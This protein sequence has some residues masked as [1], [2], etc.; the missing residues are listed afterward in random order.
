MT[1]ASILLVVLASA[2][3]V[4]QVVV[5][6]DR[7]QVTR[8]AEVKCG[9][10]TEL[11]FA[12]IPPAADFQSIRATARNATVEGL[13]TEEKTREEAFSK[14]LAKLDEELE[15]VQ[16]QLAAID[17]RLRRAQN[18]HQL[19]TQ[20]DNVAVALI[21]RDLAVSKPDPKTWS[22]A[23]DTALR[24]KLDSAAQVADIQAQRRELAYKASDLQLKRGRL[25]AASARK[26]Y[27]AE[28]LV[29]CTKG[30]GQV[31]LTYLVG[32]ASWQPAY[33]ARAEEPA[34]VEVQTFAT[35]TQATGEDWKSAKILLSTAVPS[36]DA[37]PPEIQPLWV[38]AQEKDEKKVLVRREEK[39]QHAKTGSA[40]GGEAAP[41]L[42]SRWQGLSV[43]L[44][45]QRP[46]DVPGDGSPVRLFVGKNKMPAKFA[47][48]TAPTL[49]PFVFRTAEVTNTAA[50]PLLAGNLDAFGRSG[51]VGRFALERTAT[52]APFEVTLGIED[53][54]KV[55][56]H[57]LEEVKKDAGLFNQKKR[58][59][60]AYRFEVENHSN[61]QAEIELSDRIPVSELDD[62]VVTVGE[63]TTAG[64][65]RHPQDGV[66]TWKVRLGPG[67]TTTVD[68]A[69]YVDVPDSYDL[70]GL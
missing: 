34:H 15:G 5:Y 23:F 33:E 55:K 62:V 39:I 47:Y 70:A 24:A 41:N 10:R 25:A 1:S 42:A 21:S 7:A 51:F 2:Q 68:L 6:P 4:N 31:E 18:S 8:V 63:K 44:E 20:F 30:T 48:R 12:G 56:R 38:Y 52:G 65:E 36:Q 22:T 26:E 49:A 50:F 60:Y 46:S 54:L 43:Q 16:Q 67:K 29:S 17:D 37:T 66:L 45:V 11:T 14:Q 57:V 64:Y 59:R 32:G 27:V 58:L 53:A 61:R 13:R 69:F 40:Q 35:V 9:G 19:G 3:D 28:V